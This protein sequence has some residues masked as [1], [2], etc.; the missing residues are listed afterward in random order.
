MPLL[1]KFA[2]RLIVQRPSPT[3]TQYTVSNGRKLE[4]TWAKVANAL[5]LFSRALLACA[6]A[7]LLSALLADA[8]KTLSKEAESLQPE[9]TDRRLQAFG[10]IQSKQVRWGVIAILSILLWILSQRD[11]YGEIV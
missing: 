1:R 3:T 6:I 4:T 8:W 9:P 10:F 5:S 2:T 11:S 7:Y